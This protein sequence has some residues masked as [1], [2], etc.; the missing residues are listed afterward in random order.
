[1]ERTEPWPALEAHKSVLRGKCIPSPSAQPCT[2]RPRV[3]YDF[4]RGPTQPTT[5]HDTRH[6]TIAP[7]LPLHPHAASPFSVLALSRRAS[8]FCLRADALNLSFICR[9]PPRYSQV[10]TNTTAKLKKMY[11]HIIPVPMS[12]CITIKKEKNTAA[13]YQS[14]SKCTAG[15]H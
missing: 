8:F 14:L 1:M 13:T 2:F 10:H 6:S 11:A 4:S 9:R 3:R 5:T 12:A 15:K 7:L